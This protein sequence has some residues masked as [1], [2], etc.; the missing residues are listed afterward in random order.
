MSEAFSYQ[1]LRRLGVGGHYLPP[2]PPPRGMI[3][4]KY[5]GADRVNTIIT[6]FSICTGKNIVRGG[7]TDRTCE[8]GMMSEDSIPGTV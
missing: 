8:F 6:V 5:P 4:Q 3:R 2:P 1:D 7:S